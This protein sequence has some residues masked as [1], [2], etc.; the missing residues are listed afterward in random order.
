V[1]NHAQSIAPTVRNNIL[2]PDARLANR[3]PAAL[4]LGY[5]PP[6]GYHYRIQ[7][8]CRV[9][10]TSGK[11]YFA[12]GK[13]FIGCSTRQRAA[14]KKLVGKDF[15]AGC[16]LSGTRQRLCRVQTQHPAKKS[17]RHGV[18]SI[19]RWFARCHVRGT[20]QRFF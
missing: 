4:A 19:S 10:K 17:G 1:A 7:A 5:A 11:S 8:L 2:K 15:F 16:F 6:A 13:T 9:P 3:N 18:G 12:L 14:G 20:R